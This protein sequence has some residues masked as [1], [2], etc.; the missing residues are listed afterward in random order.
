M[1]PAVIDFSPSDPPIHSKLST[2]SAVLRH[3]SP[4]VP[5]RSTIFS[6]DL[7]SCTTRR[8]SVS[9]NHR[10][11]LRLWASLPRRAAAHETFVPLPA[12]SSKARAPF[13]SRQTSYTAPP[14]ASP[15]SQCSSFAVGAV[16]QRARGLVLR[17]QQP[18]THHC[19]RL[20]CVRPLTRVLRVLALQPPLGLD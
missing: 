19:S 11:T 10:P 8:R 4:F 6:T 16:Q 20:N 17:V 18:T 5:W 7:S 3:F 13:T 1:R 2:D 15:Q 12:P 14:K 9:I